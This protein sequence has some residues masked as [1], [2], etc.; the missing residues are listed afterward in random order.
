MNLLFASGTFDGFTLEEA[1]IKTFAT[2]NIDGMFEK[3]FFGVDE[4][5]EKSGFPDPYTPWKYM[6][7]TCTD[8]IKGKHTPVFMKFVLHGDTSPYAAE[9]GSSNIGSL[10]I[11]IRFENTGLSLTTGTSMKEFIPDHTI[12]SLWDRDVKALLTRC[13]VEFE[14]L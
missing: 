13:N 3:D 10:L 1:V 11:I 14:E 9:P 2:Y 8:I 4:V 7:S 5:P 12:D 6:R